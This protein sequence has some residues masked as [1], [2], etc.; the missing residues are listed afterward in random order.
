MTRREMLGVAGSAIV[1]ASLPLVIRVAASQAAEA[2]IAYGGLTRNDQF[3]VTSY[4]GTPRVD[5]SAWRLRIDGLVENS[6][7]LDY[8]QFKHLPA[9]K[10]TLTLECIGNPP[11]GS[12]IGNE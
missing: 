11:D 2:S 5:P 3:Y 10:E 4:G 8:R 1:A 9:V 6:I 7:E 12:A